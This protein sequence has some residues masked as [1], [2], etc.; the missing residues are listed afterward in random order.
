M[1]FLVFSD[2]HG[3]DF[4][5]LRALSLNPD[6]R[7]V[8]FLGDGLADVAR[9]GARFP[10]LHIRAV[11]GNMDGLSLDHPAEDEELFSLF[12]VDVLMTHGHLFGVKGGLG[13][14]ESRA[15]SRGARVLLYGHTHVPYSHYDGETGLYTFNPGSIGRPYGRAPS[16]GLLDILPNGG[17]SLSHGSF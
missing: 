5:M 9:I 10:D 6:V 16:F 15:L 2:S 12:G 1:R 4:Y 17:I 3:Q 11:R 13:A 14:A 8:L 7:H